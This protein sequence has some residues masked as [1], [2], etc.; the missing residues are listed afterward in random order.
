MQLVSI[1]HD[2]VESMTY[3]YRLLGQ[4]LGWSKG[5][6][7]L[8]V[9]L[10]IKVAWLIVFSSNEAGVERAEPWEL[11]RVTQQGLTVARLSVFP[12]P[13]DSYWLSPA[14][15]WVSAHSLPLRPTQRQ[16]ERDWR[17][18]KEREGLYV[19]D[20]EK[21]ISYHTLLAGCFP[22][23]PNPHA[24][25]RSSLPWSLHGTPD[26]AL[27]DQA[28]SS[29]MACLDVET[30]AVCRGKFKSGAHVSLCLSFSP[31]SFFHSLFL[32]L[33]FSLFLPLSAR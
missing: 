17:D 4:Q 24:G 16:A 25:P 11:S 33:T 20:C 29:S 7:V 6:I 22:S 18:W 26:P 23:L 19:P 30:P 15:A 14:R 21:Q 12:P 32:S 10:V 8:C 31:S 5:C 28:L 9:V 27:S 13:P 3:F 1:F 2:L